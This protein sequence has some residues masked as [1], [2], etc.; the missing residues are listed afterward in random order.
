MRARAGLA[1]CLW[2][3]G[4]RRKAIEHYA[5]MLR[6]NPGDN[7][8]IRYVLINCLLSEGDDEGVEKLLDQ[9]RGDTAATWL[10]SRTLWTFRREGA[11]PKIKRLL[12]KALECN[13][14]VPL[15]LFGLK[16]LPEDSPDF[17][18]IGDENEAIAYVEDAAEIWLQTPGALEW[19]IDS[20]KQMR[21]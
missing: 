12:K 5:E 18:G 13:P 1:Q 7:Q 4:E 21:R 11:G 10:Y 14:Y 20:V 8:G 6:L 9:Y 16:E 3:L 2:L 17:I 15:Y 19:L